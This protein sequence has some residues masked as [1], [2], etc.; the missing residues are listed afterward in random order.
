MAI[1]LTPRAASLLPKWAVVDNVP[2]GI[3][4]LA[5]YAAKRPGLDFRDYCRG[6]Q[7]KDGR[8]AYFREARAISDQLADV[9][10][11]LA[12]AAPY[13]S[14]ATDPKLLRAD[15]NVARL[16]QLGG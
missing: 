3:R 8:A 4:A 12:A 9:R 16:P 2:D 5:V 1:Q 10:E 14:R 15:A 13:L 6:W 7:D 11:A